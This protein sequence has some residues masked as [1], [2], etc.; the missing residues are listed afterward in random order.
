MVSMLASRA[1]DRGFIGGV[2]VSMLA[3]RA[4][5]GV[6]G[7]CAAGVDNIIKKGPLSVDCWSK[8]SVA[9]LF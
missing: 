4:V 5:A 8:N 6:N 9:R 2:M 1:V 3:S 7:A